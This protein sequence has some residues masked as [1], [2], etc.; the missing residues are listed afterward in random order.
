MNSH[1]QT[2]TSLGTVAVLG[3]GL[4]GGSLLRALRRVA[5]PPRLI[6]WDPDRQ[7]LRRARE[8]ALLDAD[9]HSAQQAL[10]QADLVI[11]SAPPA[12]CEQLLKELAG[13]PAGHWPE[14]T[15]LSDVCSSKLSIVQLARQ[16]L[17]DRLPVF[18][19]AHPVAGTEHSGIEAARADLFD[20]CQ[21]ILTPLAQTCA[22]ACDRVESLWRAAGAAQVMRMEPERHDQ[23]MAAVSHLPH[24]LAYA[25]VD[26]LARHPQRDDLFCFAAGG[27]ADFTRIA[28][29]SPQMWQQICLRNREPILAGLEHFQSAL[30]SLQQAL[31]NEDAER[32]LEVF[33][34]ARAARA[35]YRKRCR[36]E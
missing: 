15:V 8:Q 19:P 21:V 14:A 20:R 27:F 5:S 28:S 34:R 36:D 25:L 16:L 23:L 9:C 2:R 10:E 33:Q 32:L 1:S 18:V 29:S 26:C 30:E 17:R 24:V 12:A 31:R 6:A 35:E 11:L 3:V 4:I 13:L 22:A 7:A